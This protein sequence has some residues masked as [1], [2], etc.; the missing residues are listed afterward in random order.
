MGAV[1]MLIIQ[2]AFWLSGTVFTH[3]IEKRGH[4]KLRFVIYL[5]VVT[6]QGILF[7]YV[8][9]GRT[10]VTV[11]GRILAIF[12]MSAALWSCRKVHWTAAIYD[13]IWGV[14]LWQ[15][16]LELWKMNEE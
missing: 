3:S 12:I 11:A 16:V 9:D 5:L 4:F 7:Y 14:S 8:W 6:A 1:Q 10:L 15:L 2:I 13:T